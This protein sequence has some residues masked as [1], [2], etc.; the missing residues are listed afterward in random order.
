M[1]RLQELQ[2]KL[3]QEIQLTPFDKERVKA[4][5]FSYI[6]ANPMPDSLRAK[7]KTFLNF[8]HFSHAGLALAVLVLVV[9]GSVGVS[10]SDALPGDTLYGVKVG[11]VE[12][13]RAGL[14]F[15]SEGKAAMEIN[16][17]LTRIE[18]A[19]ELTSLGRLTSDTKS[20][21]EARF[22][23]HAQ[24]AEANLTNLDA[25]TRLRLSSEFE[26]KL[27]SYVPAVPASEAATFAAGSR[28]AQMTTMSLKVAEDTAL[29]TAPLAPEPVINIAPVLDRVTQLRIEAESELYS[30]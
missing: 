7:P 8:L 18:E 5:L 13:L 25:E 1:K 10:S 11:V 30:F 9:F 27:L 26:Q 12:K 16:Q 29:M 15:T 2:E 3:K 28:S 24:K 19:T 17:A 22:V 6:D 4:N 14:S 20:D 23:S 21:L